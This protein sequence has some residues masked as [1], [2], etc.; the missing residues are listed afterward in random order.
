MGLARGS[1]QFRPHRRSEGRKGFDAAKKV[2]AR[3]HEVPPGL[4][5]EGKEV[6]ERL[7]YILVDGASDAGGR[8][9]SSRW[10][11]TRESA[12]VVAEWLGNVLD[13]LVEDIRSRTTGTLHTKTIEVEDEECARARIHK[14][15]HIR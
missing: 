10:D 13:D 4:L 9:K 8:R 6:S 1:R 15:N 12:A 2:N 5:Q 7:E 3:K 14:S 11:G